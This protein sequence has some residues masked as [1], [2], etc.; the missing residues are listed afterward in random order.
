MYLVL[1]FGLVLPETSWVKP[2]IG[3]GYY[4]N[5]S[6]PLPD[7]PA[8]Q[9]PWEYRIIIKPDYHQCKGVPR[10]LTSLWPSCLWS[11]VY[12]AFGNTFACAVG[13]YCRAIPVTDL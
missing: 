7:I 2:S 6:P 10:L 8:P 13:S 9:Q 5:P 3:E 4:L 12:W 11:L 1:S